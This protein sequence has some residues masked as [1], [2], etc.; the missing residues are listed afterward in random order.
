L[1][2]VL[3][4]TLLNLSR[5]IDRVSFRA[6]T[7]FAPQLLTS[8]IDINRMI[9]TG[10]AKKQ[11]GAAPQPHISQQPPAP[12]STTSSITTTA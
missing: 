8:L 3:K 5:Y 1:P 2:Q 10:L 6:I 11:A 7:E 12:P 4:V 9:A